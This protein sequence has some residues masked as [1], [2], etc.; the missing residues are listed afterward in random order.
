M[1][2]IARLKRQYR[3]AEALHASSNYGLLSLDQLDT[4]LNT[5][6]F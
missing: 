6:E 3:L 5:Y 2:T 4:G 1:L